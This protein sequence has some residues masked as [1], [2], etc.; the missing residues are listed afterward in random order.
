MRSALD[1][2]VS[3]RPPVASRFRSRFLNTLLMLT[4]VVTGATTA[5]AASLTVA[6]NAPTTNVDGTPLKDL[7]GYRV[8]L[9]TAPPSCPGGT[10][11]AVSSP[12]TTP[13]P[14]Q[15]VSSR[16]TALSA[17]TTYFA[18]V[19]AVDA[20]GNEGPCS[21]STSGVAQPDFS[22]TPSA[23]TSFGSVASGATVDRTFTVQNT[24]TGIISG[25]ASIAA[26]FRVVGDDSFSL[27]PG[28]SQ[29]VTVRFQPTS[30]G[31][32]AGNVNF[33]ANGDTL[34]R[35]VTGSATGGGTVTLSVTKNGTGSG[36]VTSV[37]AGI[38]CGATCTQSAS[39][40]TQVTLAAAADPGSTFVGW[41]GACSGITA[42][43]VT[44]NAGT[45][46]SATF[47]TNQTPQ[48][49]LSEPGAPKH[50]TVSQLAADASGVTFAIAWGAGR[51]AAA[52]V[53]LAEFN[54]G[55]APQQGSVTAL[56]FQLRMPYHASGAAFDGFICIWSV[57]AAGVLSADQSCNT[58]S[59]PARPPAPPVPAVSSLSPATAPA[60]GAGFTLTVNGS[61]FASTSVVRWNGASKPTTFVSPSQLQAGQLRRPRV[62]GLGPGRRRH[63]RARR[64]HVGH[65]ELHHHRAAVVF[66]ADRARKPHGDADRC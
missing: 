13:S 64:W 28:A 21:T 38:T 39:P 47:N 46:V 63:P 26:P 20:S 37:P 5:D 55:S 9:G 11:F 35:G 56:S 54:D 44:L 32:F 10:F 23:P 30:A 49:P 34:S 50:P 25:A 33:T 6:W 66:P 61:G 1:R 65:G 57:N 58:M 19:T 27:V 43:V 15:T 52:Y 29:A 40:G 62:R 4:G 18:R 12:T 53:Y 59:V 51:G 17:G 7:A 60:G 31:S 48:P 22:V 36:R 2:E 8:Y 41:S 45:S 42:C 16:V 24:S 14:G 3:A